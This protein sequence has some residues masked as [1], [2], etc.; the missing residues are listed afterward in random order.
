METFLT[1]DEDSL[2]NFVSPKLLPIHLAIIIG[3][4]RACKK[5]VGIFSRNTS[6]FSERPDPHINQFGFWD[7]DSRYILH[8]LRVIENC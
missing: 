4:G 6:I 1:E 2:G 5:F 8:I 3:I 7:V